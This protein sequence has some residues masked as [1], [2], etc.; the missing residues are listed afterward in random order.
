MFV[1]VRFNPSR[2]QNEAE[3]QTRDGQ[4][5]V[6]PLNLVPDCSSITD[7]RSMQLLRSVSHS[8]RLVKFQARSFA[9]ASNAARSITEEQNIDPF[10]LIRLD[11][12]KVKEAT[13]RGIENENPMLHA[14][15]KHLFEVRHASGGK[16]REIVVRSQL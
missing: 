8:S 3:I 7:F 12:A 4:Q 15:S 13:L 6:L 2:N 10:H 14:A 1:F 5:R 11:L 9:V 16:G